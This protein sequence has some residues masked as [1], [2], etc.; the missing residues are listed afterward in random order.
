MKKAFLGSLDNHAFPWAEPCPEFLKNKKKIGTL[1][2]SENSWFSI[3]SGISLRLMKRLRQVT[4]QMTIVF[5]YIKLNYFFVGA[6]V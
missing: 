6:I 5:E 2:D 3:R 4:G 1:Q